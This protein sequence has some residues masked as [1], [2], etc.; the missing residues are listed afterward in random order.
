MAWPID[1][2]NGAYRQRR[3]KFYEVV[4]PQVPIP[5]PVFPSIR[6]TKRAPWLRA[7]RGRFAEPIPPQVPVPSPTPL[8]PVI[9][10]TKR[11]LWLRPRRG[12]FA[13]TVPA[14]VP[15]PAPVFPIIA[16][17]RRKW[18]IRRRYA[19]FPPQLPAASLL[20]TPGTVEVF[21]E[22]VS[23]TDMGLTGVATVEVLFGAAGTAEVFFE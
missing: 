23:S 12:R 18:A 5:S 3:G 6:A 21:F 19:W 8:V 4:P 13:L 9:R 20:L 14:Q 15:I 1:R 7:R 11:A 17:T 2:R 22:P 10:F 16:V